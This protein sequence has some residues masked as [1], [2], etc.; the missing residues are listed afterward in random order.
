MTAGAIAALCALWLTW[1]GVAIVQTARFTQARE[2][3]ATE[4][5][6]ARTHVERLNDSLLGCY[7]GVDT[8]RSL[9]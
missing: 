8:L 9:R 7:N 5:A 2:A 3:L 6:N 4:K 1:F